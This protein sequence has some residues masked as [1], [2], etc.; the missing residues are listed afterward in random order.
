MGFRGFVL[1]FK[2]LLDLVLFFVILCYEAWL[3]K[4]NQLFE[5]H[6]S[7]YCLNAFVQNI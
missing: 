6:C 3:L 4:L 1:L 2:Y 7:S 5:L